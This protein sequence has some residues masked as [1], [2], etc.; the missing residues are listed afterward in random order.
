[1]TILYSTISFDIPNGTVAAVLNSAVFFNIPYGTIT[2][3]LYG[4]V[5]FNISGC[6]VAAIFYCLCLQR[7]NPEQSQAQKYLFHG[8]FFFQNKGKQT[9]PSIFVAHE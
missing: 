8:I 5:R 3:V 6:A 9:I 2:T 4:A 7:N 1:M